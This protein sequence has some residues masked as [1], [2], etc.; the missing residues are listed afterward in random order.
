[1]LVSA[2]MLAV[3]CQVIAWWLGRQEGLKQL[4]V[5]IYPSYIMAAIIS[6][7]EPIY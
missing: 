4:D 1:M 2:W 7:P 5:A 6:Q 3:G